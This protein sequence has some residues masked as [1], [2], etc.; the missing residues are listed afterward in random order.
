MIWLRLFVLLGAWLSFS[1]EPMLG[2]LLLPHY[3]GA[4]YVWGTTLMFFQ[5]VLLAGYAYA[6]WLGPRLGR[7]HLG[8]L[9]LP[10]AGLP[11]RAPHLPAESVAGL[12]VALAQTCGLP[13]LL[14]A[15]TSVLAQRW[16][17]LSALPEREHPYALYSA[18]NLGSLGALL[19]YVLVAEPLLGVRAQSQIWA[20]LYLSYLVVALLAYRVCAP[21]QALPQSLGQRPTPRSLGVWALLAAGPSALSLAVTNL[22]IVEIGNA[23]LLWVLP[24]SLYLLSFILA[25][26]RTG[27]PR[28]AVR[29]L[30]HFSVAALGVYA[31]SNGVAQNWRLGVLYMLLAFVISWS[32]HGALYDS[33]PPAAQLGWYYLALAFGGLLGGAF[34]ALIAPH[35]FSQLHEFL[36]AVLVTLGVVAALR[37]SW[38]M[39]R[40]DAWA[41]IGFSLVLAMAVG[42]GLL[43]DSAGEHIIDQ[44]RSPY[45]VYRVVD[46][47]VPGKPRARALESGHT[48]HGEQLFHA[49]GT[50]DP[51]PLT[52]YNRQSPLAEVVA[53]LPRPRRLGVIGLGIGTIAGLLDAED[54]VVFYEID[55]VVEELARSHFGYLSSPPRSEIRIGD[56]RRELAREAEL[57]AP[58]YQLLVID[59]FTG[60]SIPV[61]LLTIEALALYLERIEPGS[62]V[63]L[64][65]SNRFVPLIGMIGAGANALG[66]VAVAQIRE[67]DLPHGATPSQFAAIGNVEHLGWPRVITSRSTAWS[68]DHSSLLPLF[69][70]R[71]TR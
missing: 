28:W 63:L 40:S 52:Y 64:H 62:L 58:R 5:G 50:F 20:C 66:S 33:R 57:G 68:D 46:T 14:L 41:L 7:W 31:L 59:A 35:L 21:A 2:R 37:K 47:E 6:H 13:F 69:A 39:A 67:G 27:T 8:A 71:F 9:L 15:S 55:P 65:T 56:A 34:V 12:L 24:L 16:L 49:D 43:L 18:S 38:R 26:G 30:P 48:R 51:T 3:G 42:R 11:F 54:S 1:M 22:T 4:V 19:A 60:D 70:W 25:F 32:A 36:L 44:R 53:A 23:P 10:L 45:G 61:H 17:A 29:L